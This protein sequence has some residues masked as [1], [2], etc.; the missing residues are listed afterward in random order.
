VGRELYVSRDGAA[1][2]TLV[3]RPTAGTGGRLSLSADGS[4]L[5]WA[6]Q[7]GVYRTADSGAT[8]SAVPGLA[9]ATY[10]RVYLSSAGRGLLYGEL[11]TPPTP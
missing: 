5:L 9:F 6:P 4:V 10:G 11:V 7:A 2:W 3:P 8:W 1:S